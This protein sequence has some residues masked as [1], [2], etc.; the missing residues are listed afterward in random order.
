MESSLPVLVLSYDI[1]DFLLDFR[2]VKYLFEIVGDFLAL[3]KN[4]GA[5]FKQGEFKL[6]LA[7]FLTTQT[8]QENAMA[9]GN[10]QNKD[11]NLYQQNEYETRGHSGSLSCR[12]GLN[13]FLLINIAPAWIE[14]NVILIQEIRLG[15]YSGPSRKRKVVGVE[16]HASGKM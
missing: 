14:S 15:G 11:K 2:L 10:T 12:I 16:I 6:T 7:V 5:F 4:V 1:L 9:D 3:Q 8:E 13:E